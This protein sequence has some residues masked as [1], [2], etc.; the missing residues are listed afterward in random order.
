MSQEA[1]RKFVKEMRAALDEYS[2]PPGCT[3]ES[4]KAFALIREVID[5]MATE[6]PPADGQSILHD[7]S[8][9]T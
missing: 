1:K 7:E 9:D 2:P 5:E 4:C 6:L 8:S 3:C